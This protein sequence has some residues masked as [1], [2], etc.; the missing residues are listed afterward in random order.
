MTAP[1][2][3]LIERAVGEKIICPYANGAFSCHDDDPSHCKARK[4]RHV[5]QNNVPIYK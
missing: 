1:D 4:L 2:C 5:Q 3:L